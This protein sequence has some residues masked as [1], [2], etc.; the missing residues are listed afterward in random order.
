MFLGGLEL[1]ER[2][3]E[4]AELVERDGE[5]AQG[6]GLLAEHL[7]EAAADSEALGKMLLG[8]LELAE[9]LSDVATF[10]QGDG[11]RA[12]RVD[13]FRMWPSTGNVERLCGDVAGLFELPA[14]P[15]GARSLLIPRYVLYAI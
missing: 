10:V 7:D 12:D 2:L 11:E 14:L 4:V 9:C 5:I 1:A 8:G 13:V 6:A 15:R 3:G